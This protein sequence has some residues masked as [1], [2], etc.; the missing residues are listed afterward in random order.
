MNF[1]L[2]IAL[3]A[4]LASN[5][6]AS[7]RLVRSVEYSKEQKILQGCIVWLL[8]FAGAAIVLGVML[9]DPTPRPI[10]PGYTEPRSYG[11]GDGVPPGAGPLDGLPH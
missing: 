4:W 8:P 10:D 3:I 1:F 7:V 6:W 5:A 2:G 9:F 11:L